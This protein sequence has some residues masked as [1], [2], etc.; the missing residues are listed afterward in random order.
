MTIKKGSKTLII[1]LMTRCG[2]SNVRGL[3]QTSDLTL[4]DILHG[5]P[6]L[7]DPILTPFPNSAGQIQFKS[8][9]S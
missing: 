6:T 3:N 9:I 7:R 4:W 1:D 8:E 5:A 2:G